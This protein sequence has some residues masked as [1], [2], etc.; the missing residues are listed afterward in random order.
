M[1]PHVM[2]RTTVTSVSV[3]LD[4]WALTAEQV[5]LIVLSKIALSGTNQF[6]IECCFHSFSKILM[7]VTQTHVKVVP[8]VWMVSTSTPAAVDQVIWDYIAS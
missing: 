8:V 7:S 4:S 5:S 1:G 6:C 2:T 3:F